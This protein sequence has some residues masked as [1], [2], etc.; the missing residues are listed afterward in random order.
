VYNI[1][2]DEDIGAKNSANTDDIYLVALDDVDK[3]DNVDSLSILKKSELI[4]SSWLSWYQQQI[5]TMNNYIFIVKNSK[6]K[7]EY[8][9]SEWDV[10]DCH[11]RLTY[12]VKSDL[13]IAL[14]FEGKKLPQIEQEEENMMKNF[15]EY[16]NLNVLEDWTYNG[17]RLVSDKAKLSVYY[18]I[19]ENKLSFGIIPNDFLSLMD[20]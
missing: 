4:P 16:H 18:N 6:D 14:S 13:I 8:Y 2:Y 15:V 1:I 12:D 9:I 11:I 17:K 10:R 20:N 5:E 3:L 19:E 7:E